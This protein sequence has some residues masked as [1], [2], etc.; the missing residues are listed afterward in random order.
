ME[1]YSDDSCGQVTR[2]FA[3][4]I[5]MD[6]L[7]ESPF[8]LRTGNSIVV[9]AKTIDVAGGESPFATASSV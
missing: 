1:R 3:C 7:L 2:G 9:K 8:N 4:T 6:R 5:T